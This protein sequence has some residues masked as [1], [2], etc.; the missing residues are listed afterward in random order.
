MS[1]L[2]LSSEVAA[3]VSPLPPSAAEAL[4]TF[5]AGQFRGEVPDAG[6][7][8]EIPRRAMDANGGAAWGLRL[9]SPQA[10][11]Q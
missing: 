3:Y 7:R 9:Y 1:A 10:M 4:A 8:H 2:W 5:Y 11:A 6:R